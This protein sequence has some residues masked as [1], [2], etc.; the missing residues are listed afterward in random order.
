M[1]HHIAKGGQG[2]I[3]SNPCMGA[4]MQTE[5]CPNT[6]VQIPRE[7]PMQDTG[8]QVVDVCCTF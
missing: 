4:G 2:I 8:P 5:M 3:Q 1:D 7:S 6:T